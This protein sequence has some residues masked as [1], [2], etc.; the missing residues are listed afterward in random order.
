MFLLLFFDIVWILSYGFY[1]MNSTRTW[2][3]GTLLE[4]PLVN[5]S[6]IGDP[7]MPAD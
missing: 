5:H 2:L 6:S 3:V 7:L 4:E 1:R